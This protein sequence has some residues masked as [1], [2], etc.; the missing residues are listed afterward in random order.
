MSILCT[1]ILTHISLL[2]LS[3]HTLQPLP[4]TPQ[5]NGIAFVSE[6]E[7]CCFYNYLV[8][9]FTLYAVG[10]NIRLGLGSTQHTLAGGV[11]TKVVVINHGWP[12][13]ILSWS[14][15]G[16]LLTTNLRN[17]RIYTSWQWPQGS[18][19]LARDSWGTRIPWPC[20]L[21]WFYTTQF[22]EI[23]RKEVKTLAKEEETLF[24]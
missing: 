11:Y 13:W 5:R 22:V 7:M 8:S 18:S 17:S 14:W 1:F 4:P 15:V 19:K 24:L 3:Q 21:Y 23:G 12:P 10:P 6:A 2:S 9:R 16:G 20:F